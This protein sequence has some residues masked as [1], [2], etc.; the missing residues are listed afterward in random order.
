VRRLP[1]SVP[2]S[3]LLVYSPRG[4][5]QVSKNSR[6]VCYSLKQGKPEFVTQAVARLAQLWKAEDMDDFF[7]PDVIL[8]PAPRSSPLVSG[9]LWPAQVICREIV[10]QGLAK[11]VEPALK[12]ITRVTKSA[13]A[14]ERPD[15]QKHMETMEATPWLSDGE[16]PRVTI[17]DDVITK[18]ATLYAGCVMIRELMPRAEVKAFAVVRTISHGDV[19]N[20]LQPCVGEIKKA[21]DNVMR[22]P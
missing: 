5:S 4:E 12:R 19:E 10:A 14:R 1:S 11:A 15:I 3:S 18:G 7:G 6:T 9:A 21:W 20:I 13:G 8:I 22:V 17:V 2:F 16:A